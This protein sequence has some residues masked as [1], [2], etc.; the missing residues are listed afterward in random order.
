M[1]SNWHGV[2]KTHLICDIF[3]GKISTPWKFTNKLSS[4]KCHQQKMMK[5][6]FSGVQRTWE[7]HFGEPVIIFLNQKW[8]QKWTLIVTT[9]I[10]SP[11]SAMKCSKWTKPSGL[12]ILHQIWVFIFLDSSTGRCSIKFTV[13]G[14]LIQRTNC[15]IQLKKESFVGDA[16][17]G[18]VP[19]QVPHNNGTLN[20][21]KH[22]AKIWLRP[23][24]QID[25]FG[26]S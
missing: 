25:A 22:Y 9:K 10:T 18:L 14:F 7:N 12:L 16:W 21:Q 4:T 11:W 1:V 19:A 6:K 26:L 23:G 15:L 17:V 24:F 20:W 3:D 13:H 2:F 8:L 5:M